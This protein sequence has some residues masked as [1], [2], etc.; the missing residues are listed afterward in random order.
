MTLLSLP[1]DHMCS[2]QESLD[3]MEN[4]CYDLHYPFGQTHHLG[5][6]D[7]T[8]L[9]WTILMTSISLLSL[10]SLLFDHMY[11]TREFVQETEPWC[12]DLHFPFG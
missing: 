12:Y 3:Y 2:T 7:Q 10:I 4:C 6:L 9:T 11:S 8:T 1:F 5:Q